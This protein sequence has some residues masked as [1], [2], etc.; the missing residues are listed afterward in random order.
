MEIKCTC[1]RGFHT[2][3]VEVIEVCE[4]ATEKIA[5]I[6]KNYKK[7]Y[8]VAD[9]NTYKVAGKRAE[10]LLAAQGNLSHTYVLPGNTMAT[11]ERV[12]D[13]LIHAGIK[14]NPYD[15]NKFSDNPDY[16]LAVGS[17]SVNDVCRMVSYR[18]GIPYGVLGTAPSM[19]GYASNGAAMILGGM[20]ET[21]AAGLPRAIIAD[22]DVLSQAPLEM[23]KAGFGD[24][25][26]KYSALCDWK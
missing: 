12:G 23:I 8:L 22:V 15:I 4:N 5:D 6:L 1:E 17:G 19:D 13:V 25:I 3:P 2:A 7:I 14:Q 11:A 20:K 9:E 16:I 10:E 21:V 24:I 18:L 26:G